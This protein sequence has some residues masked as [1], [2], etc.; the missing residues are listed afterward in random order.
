MNKKILS[1]IIAGAL[2]LSLV[3]LLPDRAQALVADHNSVAQFD[4]IPSATIEQ[5][6]AN[7]RIFFG[8][9]SHGSQIR[10]GMDV[11]ADSNPTY[12]YGIS[13]GELEY[14][15]VTNEDLGANSATHYM[16]TT[17]DSLQALPQCNLVIWA[18]CGGVS[19]MTDAGFNNYIN[20]MAAME[21]EFP[22]VTFVYMTGH[23]DGTGE[24]G[25]LFYYNNKIREYCTTNNKVLFDFADI[26]TY[27]PE[28]GYHPDDVDTCGWCY[29]WCETHICP[30]D[31]SVKGCPCAHSH[32]LNCWRKGKAFWW[33]LAKLSGW[34]LSGVED[35]QETSLPAS[36]E[37]SQNYPN[38]FNPFTYISYRV[39]NSG[40]GP[41]AFTRTTL[42]IYNI[43]G[44][45]VKTLLDQ[46]EAP[47]SYD[48]IW[49][50]KDTAG[51]EVSSGIYFYQLRIKNHALTRKMVL[52]R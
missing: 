22:D 19:T 24:T 36:F 47:G 40:S 42:K 25:N 12:R 27:D 10:Y 15:E 44:E 23:L 2:F 11:L 13:P 34:G 3:L 18:W 51:N 29:T 8:H 30:S 20:N 31:G 9:T 52:L 1:T 43:R 48:I 45:R 4:S 21:A 49:D 16:V 41:G 17:R 6:K 39:P 38:P 50:G 46:E 14:H 37:L 28:G 7:F 35:D 32:C 33:L 26:E 5:V